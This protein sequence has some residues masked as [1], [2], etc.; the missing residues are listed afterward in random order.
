[1]G[2]ANTPTGFSEYPTGV[3]REIDNAASAAL[4]AANLLPIMAGLGA[5]CQA[6]CGY[7]C[8]LL[9]FYADMLIRVGGGCCW[10]TGIQG[11]GDSR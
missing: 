7:S 8:A 1:M 6:Y 3:Y 11:L 9:S 5:F 10:L 2:S 4:P